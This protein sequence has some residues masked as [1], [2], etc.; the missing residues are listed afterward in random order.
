MG[1]GQMERPHGSSRCFA[2]V[3]AQL[4]KNNKPCHPRVPAIWETPDNSFPCSP[5]NYWKAAL[6]GRELFWGTTLMP[7]SASEDR[8]LGL[9]TFFW[10]NKLRNVNL[11]KWKSLIQKAS[12]DSSKRYF[13]AAMCLTLLC[14]SS[15]KQNE[16]LLKDQW[17]KMIND[18]ASTLSCH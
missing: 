6:K 15:M 4:I 18:A 8:R 16:A 5:V 10:A 1:L 13:R 3:Y 7:H 9:L 2:F 14:K 11:S 12:A 17:K